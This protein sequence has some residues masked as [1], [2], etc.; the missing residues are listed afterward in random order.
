MTLQC[1][2][3]YQTQPVLVDPCGRLVILSPSCRNSLVPSLE[4]EVLSHFSHCMN[5]SQCDK[6]QRTSESKEI[7]QWVFGGR[8]QD[9]GPT[10]GV[11]QD[12]VEK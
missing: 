6:W 5:A 11:H 1:C 4:L 10:T 8:R 7:T 9:D 12:I 3:M 2:H